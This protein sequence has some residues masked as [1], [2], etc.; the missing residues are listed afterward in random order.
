M[1]TVNLLPGWY[2]LQQRRQ[3]NIR[4]HI[5][6][7]L[8][9]GVAMSGTVVLGLEHR[10]NLYRQRNAIAAT[11]Q[12]IGNPEPELRRL[13]TDLKRLVDLRFA[14][15]ELG[16]TIPMS[17]VIQQLQNDM[18]PG[19]ALSSVS[20]EV[21]SEPVKGSGFVGDVH[22]PPRYHDV[23]HLNIT[24][25]APNDMQ[26]AQL[27]DKI[28]RNPLF[29]DVTLDYTRTGELQRFPVRKFEIQIGMDL[30]RLTSEAPDTAVAAPPATSPA[31]PSAPLASGEPTH[32]P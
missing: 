32:G 22:N 25:I 23:A 2:R 11:L 16:N 18:T 9:L 20:V 24:G 17:A 21:R 27:I 26:I 19:M 28:S 10:S 12:T 14:R 1:K 8:L 15:A 31:F 3:K 30:E 13:K 4:V 5:G 6:V 7:M 29:S